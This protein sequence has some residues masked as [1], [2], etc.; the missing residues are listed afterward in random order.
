MMR[1]RSSGDNAI[2]LMLD[3]ASQ[4]NVRTVCVS[5]SITCTLLDTGERRT[6]PDDVYTMLAPEEEE[7]EASGVPY[8][9]PQRR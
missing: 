5:K 1:S 4:L 3:L 7:F 9:E 6:L 2:V 8:A